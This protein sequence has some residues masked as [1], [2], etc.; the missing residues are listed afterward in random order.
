MLFFSK[1][2]K[3]FGEAYNFRHMLTTEKEVPKN[4]DLFVLYP[5]CS[6]LTKGE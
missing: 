1:N 4:Q 5:A 2:Q 3:V 6:C